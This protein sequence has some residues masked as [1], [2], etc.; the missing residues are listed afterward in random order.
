VVRQG[1]LKKMKDTGMLR[2]SRIVKDLDFLKLYMQMELT[3]AY[4]GCK[5]FIYDIA[6]CESY[7]SNKLVIR[8]LRGKD[9]IPEK[10][11]IGCKYYE[12]KKILLPSYNYEKLRKLYEERK[13]MFFHRLI[14]AHEWKPAITDMVKIHFDEV[15]SEFEKKFYLKR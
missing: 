13:E 1:N 11:C 7:C 12:V 4:M 8:K 6:A 3:E 15:F 14:Q 2:L 10:H 5:Y 9:F